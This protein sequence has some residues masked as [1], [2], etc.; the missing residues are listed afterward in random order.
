[1][2]CGMWKVWSSI[3]RVN[4]RGGGCGYGGKACVIND[5]EDMRSWSDGKVISEDAYEHRSWMVLWGERL[6]ISS[7]A[8]SRDPVP[9][10]KQLY[11]KQGLVVLW[12]LILY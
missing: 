9:V 2:E 6:V 5:E 12:Y 11:S 10:S 8:H 3:Y 1:M 4:R 7:V